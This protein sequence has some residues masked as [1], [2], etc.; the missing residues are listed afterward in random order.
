[1]RLGCS[2]P[3]D[4]VKCAA[5]QTLV[6]CHCKIEENPVGDV[7]PMQLVVQCLTQAAIKLSSAGDNPH[8]VFVHLCTWCTSQNGVTIITSRVLDSVDECGRRVRVQLPPDKMEWTKWEETAHADTR[9]VTIG[10]ICDVHATR[11]EISE[12]MELFCWY[13]RRHW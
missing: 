9:N 10:H 5:V 1:M 2:A 11:S 4:T 6:N 8:A 13:R 12:D 7:E 3:T